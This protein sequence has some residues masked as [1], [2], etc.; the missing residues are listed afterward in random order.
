VQPNAAP[1]LLNETGEY[2]WAKTARA[3]RVWYA[4]LWGSIGIAILALMPVGGTLVAVF[5][6]GFLGVFVS[7]FGCVICAYR[8]QYKLKSLGFARTDPVF[9]VVGAVLALLPTALIAPPAVLANAR[10]A[11]RRA[12]GGENTF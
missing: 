5:S 8:V 6:I 10:K 2:V 1:Q 7:M 9:I 12:E 11:A 3:L 4:I